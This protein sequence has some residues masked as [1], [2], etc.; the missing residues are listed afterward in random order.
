MITHVGAF[1]AI[2]TLIAVIPGPDTAIAT[3][4]SLIGG[5]RAGLYTILGIALG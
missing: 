3:R 1:V 4:N 5:R 2:S